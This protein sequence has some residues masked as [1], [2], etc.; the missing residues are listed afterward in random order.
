L[1]LTQERVAAQLHYPIRIIRDL[2]DN[3]YPKDSSLVFMKGYLRSYGRLLELSETTLMQAFEELRTLT[4][5][6]DT[7]IEKTNKISSLEES[8]KDE[9]IFLPKASSN[10]KYAKNKR[11][12]VVIL[13][14]IVAIFLFRDVFYKKPEVIN[15]D[16]MEHQEVKTSDS[17][18]AAM[19]ESSN[20]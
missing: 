14:I 5:A 11:W 13:F 2:E 17:T 16:L 3:H 4:H 9:F 8:K 1:Q 20:G 12:Y 19:N 18:T 15:A 7:E 10:N 6:G